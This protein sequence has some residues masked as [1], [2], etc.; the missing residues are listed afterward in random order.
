GGQVLVASLDW[1][2]AASVVWAVLPL[3]GYVDV[4]GVF[5]LAQVL[6]MVS[7]VPGG[8]GLFETVVLFLRPEEDPATL[9]AGMLVYRVIYYFVPLAFALPLL[10]WWRRPAQEHR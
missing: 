10:L 5:L 3:D 2:V 4:L 1:L 6:A 9:V 7:N 8:M